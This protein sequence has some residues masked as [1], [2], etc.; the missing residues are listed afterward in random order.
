MEE[1][2]LELIPNSMHGPEQAP[3]MMSHNTVLSAPREQ[4]PR[5]VS[6]FHSSYQ[7]PCLI[8][9]TTSP[10]GRRKQSEVVSW[11]IS[12]FLVFAAYQILGLQCTIVQ[13]QCQ[14]YRHQ[15]VGQDTDVLLSGY[16]VKGLRVGRQETT[17][18]QLIQLNI[19]PLK[20][21]NIELPNL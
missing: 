13:N 3:L 4:E 16:P 9:A 1:T 2:E 17:E 18:K 14:P 12:N 19:P 21:E 15:R 6:C 5:H 8:Y 11:A 7:L 20:H 10:C